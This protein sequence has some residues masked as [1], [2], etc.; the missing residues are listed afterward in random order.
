MYDALMMC[1]V[2]DNRRQKLRLIDSL[3]SDVSLKIQPSWE[4]VSESIVISCLYRKEMYSQRQR[5]LL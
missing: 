3:L 1:A 2:M 4:P 5:L